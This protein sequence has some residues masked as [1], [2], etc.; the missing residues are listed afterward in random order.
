M[1]TPPPEETGGERPVAGLAIH[2]EAARH[3]AEVEARK[4]WLGSL[5]TGLKAL[6]KPELWNDRAKARKKVEALIGKVRPEEDA[7]PAA[8]W[9]REL[10]RRLEAERQAI[11][12]ELG[13]QLPRACAAE[14]IRLRVDSKEDP[15][16]LRLSPFEVQ[17]SRE[18]G[19]AKLFFA[20]QEV[21]EGPFPATVARILAEREAALRRLGD[22]E[23]PAGF[24]AACHAAWRAARAAR[25]PQATEAVE[26]LDFLPF[27]A[28]TFQNDRFREQPLARHFA[29]YGRA[30]FAW[31][32]LRLRRHGLLEHGGVRLSLGVATG[33]SAS[34]K[35]RVLYFEDEEGK[36][37]FK[38]TISFVRGGASA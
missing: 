30:R 29:D 12:S 2:E 14:G 11:L 18:K 16:V 38:L 19:N 37:E 28:L 1:V 15:V 5:G 7:L 8:V 23:D 13:T 22:L 35:K 20:R 27:L 31:D 10:P 9:L 26:I 24:F 32:V 25:G 33:R 34:S 21:S 36:G 3:V 17:I 6:A 4:K